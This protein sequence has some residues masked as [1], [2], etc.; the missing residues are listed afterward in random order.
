MTRN[1]G[2]G[3]R[4]IAIDGKEV[5]RRRADQIKEELCWKQSRKKKKSSK[6]IQE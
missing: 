4:E 6:E 3:W 1:I 5:N 2:E